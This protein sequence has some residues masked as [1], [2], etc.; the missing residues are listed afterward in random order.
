MPPCSTFVAIVHGVG[1][2]SGRAKVTRD[3]LPR[4]LAGTFTRATMSPYGSKQ[5][6]R[7]RDGVDTDDVREKKGASVGVKKMGEGKK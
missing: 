5:C 4:A 1:G 7:V 2:S 3:A 6:K